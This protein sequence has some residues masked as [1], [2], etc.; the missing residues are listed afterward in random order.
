MINLIGVRS[1]VAAAVGLLIAK[2]VPLLLFVGA[3]VFFVSRDVF[4]SQAAGNGD[5]GR[6]ALLLL[7]AYAGFENTPAAAGEFRNP[8]RDVP[9]ALLTQIAAI[10]LLYI[11]VQFVALGTLPEVASSKTPLAD[12]ATSFLGSGAGVLLTAGAALS[13]LGTNSNSVLNGPRYLLALSRDGFGPRMLG[14]VHPRF[15]TPAN[16]I[17]FQAAVALPLALTD[18]FVALAELSVVVRLVTYL[19]TTAAV[20][21]LRRK[22]PAAEGKFRIPGGLLVPGLAS[23]L[24]IGLAVNARASNLI[25]AAIAIAVGAVF[26]LMRRT[27]I[28]GNFERS[29]P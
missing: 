16:A 5:W 2:L 17:A 18:S 14:R 27:E 23:L 3:G 24:A 25:A 29:D 21:V 15:Q 1:G 6:A 11:G 4:A 8:R 7:F 12:A 10:T 26:F 13:I 28:D 19:G 20:P 22:L 9:F